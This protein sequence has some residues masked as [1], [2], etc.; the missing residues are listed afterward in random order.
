[1]V[2]LPA[3]FRTRIRNLFGLEG[4]EW[5]KALPAL[6]E[7]LLDR[8]SLSETQPIGQLTY[9]YLEY[10]SSPI[11]GSV[12]LKIGFPNPELVTEIKTL[13]AYQGLK[14]VVKLLNFDI[15]QGALLL[16]RINP[17]RNLTSEV[18]DQKAAQIAAQTMGALR[19]PEPE[20]RE[21]PTM[22]EWCQ[23]FS[24]YRESYGEKEGPLPEAILRKGLGLVKELLETPEERYL[25]HGDLHH[26]NILSREDGSWVVIDPKGV[27]G[28]LAFE[29]GPFLGNPIPD[30]IRQPNLVEI[31]RSRL[32]IFEEITGLDLHRLTAWSFCR[33]LLSAIWTIEEG[34]DHLNY[35]VEITQKIGQLVK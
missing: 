14:G 18:D 21:F 6:R 32:R 19:Q 20:G 24:R 3:M 4:N 17:G 11:H 25:L 1:M 33:T 15:N 23:G 9:N 5:L 13:Q 28:E 2:P 16:E 12:V 30:L 34:D 31:L 26:Y 8:W 7:S 10:A 29:V 27:I 35:W 22:E